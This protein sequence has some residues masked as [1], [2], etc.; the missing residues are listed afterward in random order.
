MTPSENSLTR[1]VGLRASRDFRHYFL[2]K[3][4][5]IWRYSGGIHIVSGCDFEFP[6]ETASKYVS[7]MTDI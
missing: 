1:Y 5:H 7:S 6:G 3:L 4:G 2:D